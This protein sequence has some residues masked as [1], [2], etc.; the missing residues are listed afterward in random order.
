[1]NN[2][3]LAMGTKAKLQA[4]AAKAKF[5][6]FLTDEKSAKGT[7]E[8]G[9]GLYAAIVIGVIV[10][11]IVL[12]FSKTGFGSIGSFFQDGITGKNTNPAGWG[13]K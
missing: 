6:N 3:L 7:A 11:T 10:L 5:R 1:M 4:D 12:A 2:T 9:Y 8:E 13:S